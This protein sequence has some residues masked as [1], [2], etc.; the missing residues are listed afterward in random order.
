MGYWRYAFGA[1]GLLCL[2]C[3]APC[4]VLV[5]AA[6]AVIRYRARRWEE[7]PRE[8][9]RGQHPVGVFEAAFAAPLVAPPYTMRSTIL[10]API[11]F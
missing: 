7:Q 11:L 4:R 9:E 1:A 6:F 2:A 3:V 5:V 10:P 8:A